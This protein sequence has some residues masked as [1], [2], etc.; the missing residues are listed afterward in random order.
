MADSLIS[1]AELE[2]YIGAQTLARL[3][4]D[5][6]DDTPNAQLL[7][8]VIQGGTDEAYGILRVAFPS[9]AQIFTLVQNDRSAKNAVLD[10][11][12]GLAGQRRPGLLS[13]D[14]RT[15]YSGFRDRGVRTLERI[16]AGKRRSVGETQ[17]GVNPTIRA[18]TNQPDKK[19]VFASTKDDP[20]GPGG[21]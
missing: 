7:E 17:A 1:Q 3:L 11:A 9:D 16:A 8:D 18:R 20:T 2:R 14:G 10:I 15:P 13:D 6:G 5:T 19:P 21:F 4:N 12:V